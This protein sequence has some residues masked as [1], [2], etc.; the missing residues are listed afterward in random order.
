MSRYW[1]LGCLAL[2]L[3]PFQ[4]IAAG[5]Q[6]VSPRQDTGR[7]SIADLPP[8]VG[9]TLPIVGIE[10]GKETTKPNALTSLVAKKEE[11]LKLAE[12][13][14]APVP[15]QESTTSAKQESPPAPKQE[16]VGQMG[17]DA[18]RSTAEVLAK[19]SVFFPELA[20]SRRPLRPV[21][22]FE[23]FADQ[24]IAPSRILGSLGGAG[25]SQA[26]NTLPAFGQGAEGYAKRFGSSMATQAS[27]HFFGTFVIPSLLHDDPRY[28]VKLHASLAGR[29]GYA[30]SRL[31]VTRKDDGAETTN[32]PQILGPLLAESLADSYLPATEQTAGKTFRRYGVRLA[33]TAVGNLAKEY[34]PTIFRNLRMT[35]TAPSEGKS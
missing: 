10:A 5:P 2:L 19:R 30:L 4:L 31:V 12:L 28:F 1:A 29:F 8:S 11:G 15:K 16:T 18:L 6:A 17:K 22:K 20:T 35:Q 25:I 24:S 13:P 33:L 7:S 9:T 32:W 27:N 26:A 34:W 21:Q 14:D 3:A 23:L